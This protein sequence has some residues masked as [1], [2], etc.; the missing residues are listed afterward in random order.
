M[1]AGRARAARLAGRA[2]VS[3]GGRP[4]LPPPSPADRLELPPPVVEE[5]MQLNRRWLVWLPWVLGLV[6]L[7][8]AAA[9][10]LG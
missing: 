5:R 3:G 8:V 7:G 4:D 2:V 1:A 6:G 10:L 9:L